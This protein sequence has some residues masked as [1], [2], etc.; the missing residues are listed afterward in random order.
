MVDCAW[1]DSLEG[2]LDLLVHPVVY[3]IHFTNFKDLL[4]LI[5]VMLALEVHGLAVTDQFDILNHQQSEVVRGL[6][7]TFLHG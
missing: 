3:K 1:D 4:E 2:L 7:K 5:E 6:L